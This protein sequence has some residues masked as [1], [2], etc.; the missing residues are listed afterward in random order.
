[1]K[2]ISLNTLHK[3]AT[4]NHNSSVV[5]D[6]SQHLAGGQSL[7]QHV[8]SQN[9]GPPELILGNEEPRMPNNKQGSYSVH[10]KKL[11]ISNQGHC[12]EDCKALARVFD[13]KVILFAP[14]MF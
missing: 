13:E 4:G 3:N 11:T 7:K 9:Y 1:M 2:D 8:F 12:P 10:G 14:K 6:Y 5:V